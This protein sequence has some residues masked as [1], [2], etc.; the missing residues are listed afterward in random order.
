MAEWLEP[1]S[2]LV[3]VDSAELLVDAEHLP[4][5]VDALYAG[6]ARAGATKDEDGVLLE[7]LVV[8]LHFIFLVDTVN[9]MEVKARPKKSG[10]DI[11]ASPERIAV[12]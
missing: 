4:R 1:K 6:C 2:I 8:D 10:R 12:T 7:R 9:C 3:L 5:L 11:S